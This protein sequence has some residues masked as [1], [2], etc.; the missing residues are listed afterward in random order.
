MPLLICLGIDNYVRAQTVD[1]RPFFLRQV[2][3]GNK[4]SRYS[5]LPV[6]YGS[7]AVLLEYMLLL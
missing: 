5:E 7:F 2:R 6:F 4:A 3:P 1:A